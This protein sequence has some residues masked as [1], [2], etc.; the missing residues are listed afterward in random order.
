VCVFG[1]VAW[2]DA[3]SQTPQTPMRRPS[4]NTLHEHLIL[5]EYRSATEPQVTDPGVVLTLYRHVM[6]RTDGRPLSSSKTEIM[7]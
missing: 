6:S 7:P 3:A 1:V 2:C 4:E 5:Y